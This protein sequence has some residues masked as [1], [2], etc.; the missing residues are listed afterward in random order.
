MQDVQSITTPDPAGANRP[1]I[2]A[3]PLVRLGLLIVVV[4]AA[5]GFSV[6]SGLWLDDHLHFQQLQK[7]GWNFRDLV[8]ASTLDAGVKR[9]RFWG[10]VEHELRFFRPVAFGIMKAEYTLV[11][12]RPGPM[13]V[14][15]LLW[16]VAV[17]YMVGSLVAGL[18][19]DR[20]AGTMA[21]LLFAAFPDHVVTVYW[22]A[23]QTELM[24]AFFVLA[25]TLCYA[26][27]AGWFDLPRKGSDPETFYG[28]SRLATIPGGDAAV[29]HGERGQTP[30]TLLLALA[31]F[32]LAMG[33]RE[34]AI[35][36][37]GILI[38]GDILSSGW[39]ICRRRVGV[40]L[41]LG[42][43]A[44][45]YVVVRKMAL[46]G[47]AWPHRP[48]VIYPGDPDF[49]EFASRK[50]LY[51]LGGLFMYL[52]ILPGAA[53]SYFAE[54]THLLQI[55]SVFSVL[56]V[57]LALL[58]WRRWMLLLGIIWVL[59][60]FAPVLPVE[61]SPHHLYLP[62]V[63]A[64]LLLSAV[65][66]GLWRTIKR[67][68]RWLARSEPYASGIVG[69]MLLTISVLACLAFGWLYVFGTASEDQLVSDVLQRGDRLESG[70]ELFFINQ[71][72]VAGWPSAAIETASAGRLHDL[73]SYTL[74]L[75]DEL[76]LMTQPSYVTARD[77]YTL[78][79]QAGPPGWMEGASGKVFAELS[80]T[81]WPFQAG[82]VVKGPVFDVTIEEVDA[83]SGGIT[84]LRIIFHEPIDKPGRH[85]YFGSPYQVAYPLH[86][87]LDRTGGA[88]GS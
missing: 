21:S 26:R 8:D 66:L 40:Y 35:V 12:W 19:R 15:N 49:V 46:A 51:Y 37:P 61:P 68:W 10:S 30:G 54:K 70:D 80:G 2:S 13:H 33:C 48:Y 4:A 62:G 55:G 84:Q 85:F 28:S 5:H 36:L 88:T 75:A 52:P 1:P 7:A 17:A 24:V 3:R 53:A 83:R 74:T 23:C 6:T 76:V 58:L 22:I 69:G 27:W 67:H 18:L 38:A 63:G 29:E 34:N 60:I 50:V 11:G 77:R 65:L 41:V 81:Q 16:H 43:M 64:A 82:Q 45:L 25:A 42:A 71:P 44:V 56:I 79:L 9:V 78:E 20:V 72:M 39:R 87:D 73:K 86:F 32:A 14:F 47:M 57:F 59:L 31:A